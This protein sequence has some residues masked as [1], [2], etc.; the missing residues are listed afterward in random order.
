MAPRFDADRLLLELSVADLL[1][2]PQ[3][4]RSLGFAN[5][6]GYERMW[7]GQAIH[8]RYQEQAIRD[9]PTFQHEVYL[10]CGFAHRGWRIRLRGRADGLRRQ[11]DGTRVVEEIK[12]LR[13]GVPLKPAARELYER[14]ARIY[15]WMIAR[16]EELPPERVRA[17]LV[18]IEIGTDETVREEIATDFDALEA[19]IRQRLNALLRG[20]ETHRREEETRRRAA[21]DLVFPYPELR[22][23]QDEILTAVDTA[24]DHGEHVLVEAPT[25]LGKTAA[26]LY[27][28]LRHA[29]TH[30]KRIFVLTAKT[31]QQ[32]MAAEVLRLLNRDG[33][34]RSL[35]LRAKAKMCANDQILCHE[36]YCPFAKDYYAKLAGSRLVPRLLAEGDLLDPDHL[37]QAAEAAKVCPFEVSLELG[38]R[39]QVTVCDYNYVFDPY[40]ALSEFG[41]DT[42]LR[43]TIVIIDEIHNLVDR[44]R[45]YYSPELSAGRARRAAER[46]SRGGRPI[47]FRIEELLV[48]LAELIEETVQS[49]LEEAP[50]LDAPVFSGGGGPDDSSAEPDRAVETLLP[51]DR[52]WMLRRELDTAFIDYLEH[53]RETQ[54]MRAED[55]F[56]ELYFDYLKF[57]NGMVLLD[58][59]FSQCAERRST[60][61]YGSAGVAGPDHRIRILCKDPSRF[62]GDVLS[63][64]H[65]AV[66]LSATLSPPEFYRDLLGFEPGRTAFV[67][68]PSPF[69]ARHRRVVIDGSVA[70]TWRERPAN[71]GKIAAR[72]GAFAGAV[73]GNCLALFPSYV[74]LTEV[75]GRLRS[76]GKRVLIQERAAGDREREAILDTLRSAVLGDVL[77]LAVAGGVFAE[78]VDYPGEM[79][80]AVAVVGPCLPALNLEQQLLREYYD[81]RFER[82]FEYAFVVPGM[83]RVV[84]A[85]GRLIRSADD[86]GVI[87]L[88]DQRF[89]RSPYRTHLP[90]DWLPAEGLRALTGD[91]ARAA[92]EFFLAG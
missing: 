4:L 62:L 47:H 2:T 14:Q 26:A 29:L 38:R 6:G 82:G 54:S 86:T 50:L 32:D 43:D 19:G 65:S 70:T 20:W 11:A 71:Y 81:Q 91:P 25:G 92:R 74:F 63:R 55:P 3:L 67:S 1:E 64:V 39:V 16:A 41:P 53:Q 10:T 49:A 21:R 13:R 36:E 15:A 35:R 45:G 33:A 66:G 42:D 46:T 27:P 31:L 56:V 60:D 22:P 79:L 59:A 12:S 84:Q 73:P 40:V 83:T 44:G 75:A 77:L 69:P 89:L 34:F 51:Q 90:S 88:L 52:L 85:A 48:E 78:G 80:K 23:G 8:S 87:A 5:R 68:V 24:L 57:L 61:G 72:L 17:E 7:L 9:D 58:D 18:L 76:D 37:F 30:G 28:A